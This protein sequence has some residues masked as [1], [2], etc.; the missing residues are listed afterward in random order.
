MATF[1]LGGPLSL[2]H[3]RSLVAFRICEVP[4]TFAPL[5]LRDFRD[6]RTFRLGGP[7]SHLRRGN[8]PLRAPVGLGG[9]LGLGGASIGH[10][11]L[12]D[13]APVVLLRLHDQVHRLA[14]D[15]QLLLVRV[16][17]V[18]KGAEGE[19]EEVGWSGS[20]IKRLRK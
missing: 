17:A 10:D 16:Q 8:L 2:R 4:Y 5:D 18:P 19:E 20:G 11:G 9:P 1:A 13:A 14:A 12:D 6:L 15:V 7:R 3:L